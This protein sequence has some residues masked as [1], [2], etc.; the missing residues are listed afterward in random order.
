VRLVVN[1]DPDTPS[2]TSPGAP[3]GLRSQ[4]VEQFVHANFDPAAFLNV[5][6][7][8]EMD[9]GATKVSLIRWEVSDPAIRG[10]PDQQTL[11]RL[12][13]AALV[14]AYPAR[15]QAVQDWLD[16]R[17]THPPP[18]PKEHAWSYMAGWYAEHG[19]ESFYSNLWNDAAVARELETRLRLSG[20]WQIV[21][22]MA[23]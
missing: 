17:S 18:N 21:E 13:S 16:N 22:A 8:I 19:C 1:V 7:E 11:E 3:T 23:T 9:G 12:V 5:D 20:A 14:A 10:L 4:D 2:G 15:G 6:G